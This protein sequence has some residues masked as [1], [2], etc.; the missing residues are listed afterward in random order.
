MS[1][2]F[3]VNPKGIDYYNA[4]IDELIANNIEPIATMYHFDLPQHIQDIGGLTNPLFVDYFKFYAEVLFKNFGDRVKTWITFNE[5]YNFCV[6]GYA[7]GIIAPGI[8]AEGYAEYLCAH[9]VLE[10]HA[11]T[12]HLYKQKFFDDQKGKI[13][14]SLNSRYFYPFDE[15]VDE[16]FCDQTQDFWV[17]KSELTNHLT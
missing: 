8:K 13:G 3:I 9:H 14:I 15:T 11:V 4:L 16:E 2:G 5:P 6:H 17:R 10:A 7:T 1:G 12:Y